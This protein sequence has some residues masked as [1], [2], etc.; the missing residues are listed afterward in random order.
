MSDK[1]ISDLRRRMIADMTIRTFSY[2]TQRDYI[3]Q[4]EAFT[5]FLR[6]SPDSATGDDIR[7]FQFTQV[8]QGGATE[9]KCTHL[10]E[11]DIDVRV[12]QVLLGRATYCPRTTG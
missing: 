8:E 10:L 6:R 9:D 3:R 7:R 11:S 12:I 2:K 4:I 5:S 1:P